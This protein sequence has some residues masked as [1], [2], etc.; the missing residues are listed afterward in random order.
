LNL[1]L[2]DVSSKS[3]AM[4]MQ[5]NAPEAASSSD[6]VWYIYMIRCPDGAI[7]TGI[8]TDVSRRFGEHQS[9]KGAKYLRG[10][11][12]LTLIYQKQAG[13]HSDAL[14][15]EIAMKKLSKSE[16]EGIIKENK[17]NNCPNNVKTD[18]DS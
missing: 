14:K 4:K 16:K 7:Y 6:K 8:S 15:L 10:K 5:E 2:N 9:G 1:A 13:S 17:A 11:S 3:R 18:S 12:P